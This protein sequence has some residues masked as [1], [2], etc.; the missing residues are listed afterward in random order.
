M[1]MDIYLMQKIVLDSFRTF[2][3]FS[4]NPYENPAKPE[5][6]IATVNESSLCARH[7]AKS[8]VFIFFSD[9]ITVL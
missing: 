7:W 8:F 5:M 4:F 9:F 3:F 1:L 2:F 6:V